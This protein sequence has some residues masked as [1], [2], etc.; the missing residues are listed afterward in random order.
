VRRQRQIL[1]SLSERYRPETWG[2]RGRS[3]PRASY[4]FSKRTSPEDAVSKLVTLLDEVDPEWRSYVTVW[5]G[6]R[7]GIA[8]AVRA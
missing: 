3:R 7:G 8:D 2:G 1:V 6:G 4:A 5:D